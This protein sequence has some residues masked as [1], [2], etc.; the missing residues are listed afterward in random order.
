MI[1]KFTVL[2][3]FRKPVVHDSTDDLGASFI[4]VTFRVI[5]YLACKTD[6]YLYFLH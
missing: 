4:K 2:L 5:I 1:K 3:L 6:Y